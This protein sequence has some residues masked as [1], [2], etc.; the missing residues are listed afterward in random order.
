MWFNPP[1]SRNV[2]TNIG[3]IFID[4]IKKH[5]P[6]HHRLHKIFNKNNMKISYS[7]MSNV[8]SIIKAHDCKIMKPVDETTT[9]QNTCNCRKPKNCPLNGECLSRSLI[10][11]A[12]VTSEKEEKFYVGLVEGD[13]KKRWNNHN[14]SFKSPVHG[15]STSL[16]SYI[17]SLRDR[18]CD[19]NIR[20]E[21]MKRTNPY[22]C[23]AAKCNLCMEEKLVILESDKTKMLNERSELLSKCRHKSK[24]LLCNL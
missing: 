18:G 4:L 6:K 15:H 8:D 23:G 3:R 19:Y 21:I 14:Q 9:N 11:K 7:C 17:W 13:F 12:T 20:W 24:F 2:R 10:Y 1:F 16:S 22:E 5:F